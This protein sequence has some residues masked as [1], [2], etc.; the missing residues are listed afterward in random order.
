MKSLKFIQEQLKLAENL[1]PPEIIHNHLHLQ[2]TTYFKLEK[3]YCLEILLNE[4][5]N[6]FFQ[7]AW[8]QTFD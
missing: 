8:Q 4:T 6:L 2:Q 7:N 3:R 1:K 5:D